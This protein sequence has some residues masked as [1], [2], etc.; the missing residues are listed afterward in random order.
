MIDVEGDG[1]P[2]EGLQIF[3]HIVVVIDH[4][5]ILLGLVAIIKQGG[6]KANEKCPTIECRMI[7]TAHR[8]SIPGFKF[9]R[10]FDACWGP[11]QSFG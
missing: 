3:S 7:V 10:V 2:M 8:Q 5:D 9:R 4:K 1:L 6:S 11:S